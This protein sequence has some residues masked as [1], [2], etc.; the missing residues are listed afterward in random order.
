MR[1]PFVERYSNKKGVGRKRPDPF[2][3]YDTTMKKKPYNA[4]REVRRIIGMTQTEF[5][6]L[7]GAS[8]DAV[9]S[10]ETGRNGL[11]QAFARR[12]EVATGVKA[13]S[14]LRRRGPLI[15]YVPFEGHLPYTAQLFER[16]RESYWGRTD[17]RSAREHLRHC[18]DALRLV[19]VAAARP[20]R[21]RLRF[22]LPAVVDSFRQWCERTRE[23]FKLG[24]QIEEQL[25]ERKFTMKLVHPYWRWREMAKADP[26]LCRSI[27]FKDDKRKGDKE[28]LRVEFT[29]MPLW[30]PGKPMRAPEAAL[31]EELMRR[32]RVQA[33]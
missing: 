8:K 32:S 30:Q 24:P 28:S 10:W 11:S 22:R 31:P 7:I 16:H 18:T 9:A 5:A 3:L 26:K 21:G 4:V 15:C 6:V 14:L 17:E 1:Y 12:I 2:L 27:G 19:M 23:E 20:G 25:E 13:S 33:K 29:C